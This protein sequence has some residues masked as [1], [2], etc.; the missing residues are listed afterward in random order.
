M[1]L[2]RALIVEIR[3]AMI[4]YVKSILTHGGFDCIV[5]SEETTAL[6][7]ASSF[8]IDLLVIGVDE[9]ATAASILHKLVLTSNLPPIVVYAC[10]PHECDVR[11]LGPFACATIL[12]T[13]FR[14]EAYSMP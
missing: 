10:G 8:G 5:A 9:A 3:P 2:L 13:P 4:A 14:P 6:R 11:G 7:Y 1:A 12:S